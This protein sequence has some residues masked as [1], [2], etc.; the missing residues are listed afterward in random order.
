MYWQLVELMC[1]SE[2]GGSRPVRRGRARRLA[3]IVAAVPLALAG[4]LFAAPAVADPGVTI[5]QI[6]DPE[7]NYLVGQELDLLGVV[8]PNVSGHSL[9]QLALITAISAQ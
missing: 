6:P 8:R 3:A 5:V 7:L 4:A 1:D 2:P 9:E